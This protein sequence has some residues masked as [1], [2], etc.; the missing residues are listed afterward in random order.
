MTHYAQ[1]GSQPVNNNVHDLRGT[2][3]RG[4]DGKE[5]GKVND[6]VLEHDTMEI[7]Y[8]VVDRSGWLE[9]GTFLLPAA[10][11]SRDKDHEDGLATGVTKEQ[12][13]NSPQYVK[14]SLRSEDEWKKYEQEFKKYWDDQPV[15]HMKD[16]YRIITPP[17]EPAPAQSGS[18][19]ERGSRSADSELNAAE[20]FPDRISDVFSDTA[21]NSGQV[22]LRPKSVARAEA[23]A[24]GV[25][26]LK[27][28]WWEAFEN[29]LKI[30]KSDIQSQCP[31]CASTSDKE[32]KVA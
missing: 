7:R 27:P 3:V 9:A 28:H 29:Y 30:N 14:A 6:V 11:V 24:P 5:L 23:S 19:R 4:F 32:S 17:E 26:L 10:Q 21:P 15:M 25:T 2:T 31:H 20:L 18:S 22:T 8:L 16:T 1:L 13:E 12:V